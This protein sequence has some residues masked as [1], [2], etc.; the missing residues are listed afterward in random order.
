[1]SAED[2]DDL[3]G[4]NRARWNE[5]SEYDDG[6]HNKWPPPYLP[7]EDADILAAEYNELITRS[8]LNV[9]PLVVD[10]MVDR[11]KVV[12]FRA[13][14]KESESDEQVWSWW[15][16]SHLDQ[17]QVL[18]HRD[19]AGLRD[20]FVLVSPD[21][22][23]PKFAPQSPLRVAFEL[24]PFDPM[25]VLR[26]AKMVN[27]RAWE[28]TEDAIISYVRG[29]RGT[30][31]RIETVTEHAAG[32]CPMV[33]FP[34]QLD[35]L[36][37]SSSEIEPVMPVQRRIHQTVFD[38]LLLQRSQAWRQRWASGIVVDRDEEGKPLNP[39]KTGADRM[40][41]GDNPDVK[42][43]EFTQADL[44]GLLKAVQ[45]DIQAVALI[46]RTPPHYLP[47]SSISNIS[48]EAL[49]A[50]EAALESRVGERQLLWG[51]AGEKAMR[52]G[53]RMVGREIDDSAEVIWANQELRSEAQ[54]VDAALKL[55]SMGVPL[56]YLLERLSL[57]PN[58]IE[59]VMKAVE[60]QKAQEAKAQAA[61]FGVNGIE[62]DPAASN[63]DAPDAP[64]T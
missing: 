19:A 50:L 41:I 44:T 6:L 11:L 1:V 15:Q 34:N 64:A 5:I 8:D 32:E 42:F 26:A 43:G 30:R 58:E 3:L 35:S 56:E 46:T 28:Y 12:G 60:K 63:D 13:G 16:K 61:A 62:N 40:L 18:I 45:E 2:L 17:R 55:H 54:R 20:G 38:R 9:L 53:G 25:R 47:G 39:F 51:E 31:W 29:G 59:R 33:R 49:T 14:P 48:A 21:G 7:S 24:D 4:A 57:T 22:D 23:E 52:I 37:R 27:D 36:G 10:A